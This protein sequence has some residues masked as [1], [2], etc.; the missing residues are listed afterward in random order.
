MA[1]WAC[2]QATAQ[3]PFE[4]KT[5]GQGRRSMNQQRVPTSLGDG[6]C[7]HRFREIDHS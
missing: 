7:W 4:K 5:A 6:F 2:Q 1:M 3:S